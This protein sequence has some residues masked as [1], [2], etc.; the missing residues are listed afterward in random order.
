MIAAL[1]IPLLFTILVEVIVAII[2][3][4]RSKLEIATVILINLITNPIL[5]YFLLVDGQI[6]LISINLQLILFLEV[7]IVL[8]EWMLL[9]FTL[10][11]SSKKLL[12]LSIVMN[13]CSVMAGIVVFQVLLGMF[14]SSY[15]YFFI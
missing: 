14:S 9:K 13:F 1:I 12:L 6:R 15:S 4:Y 3:G 11:Q 10:K 5:N 2:F 7:V 8:S